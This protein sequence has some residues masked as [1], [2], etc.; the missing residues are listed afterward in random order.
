VGDI[1][2]KWEFSGGG[3]EEYGMLDA[4]NWMLDTGYWV[5]DTGY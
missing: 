3:G 4:G 1:F 5:L 2:Y